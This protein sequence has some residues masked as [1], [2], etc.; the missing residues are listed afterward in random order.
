MPFTESWYTRARWTSLLLPSVPSRACVRACVRACAC[1]RVV[2]IH[3]T[4]KRTTIRRHRWTLGKRFVF[5]AARRTTTNTKTASLSARLSSERFY[6]AERDTNGAHGRTETVIEVIVR[7]NNF[8]AISASPAA[9]VCAVCVC[10][11]VRACIVSGVCTVLGYMPFAPTRTYAHVC[12]HVCMHLRMSHNRI[13]SHLFVRAAS[14]FSP[15]SPI[16]S[17]SSPLPRA[18]ANFS[19]IL[20]MNSADADA[21]VN[22]LIRDL[23]VAPL[24]VLFTSQ[25][26]DTRVRLNPMLKNDNH[27]IPK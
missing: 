16:L 12:A 13:C 14:S 18:N 19:H 24:Q 15:N 23:S 9:T 26:D 17:G 22:L 7:R 3:T 4:G 25:A 6:Y 8:S 11:R 20:H 21:Y 1:A 10:V 27:E 5:A 2:C